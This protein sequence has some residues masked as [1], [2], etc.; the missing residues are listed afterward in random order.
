MDG[1]Y[2]GEPSGVIRAYDAVTGRLA[3]AF[4]PAAYR[5]ARRTA[6]GDIYTPRDA[7]QLGSHQR[8]RVA[9]PG[10][11]AD[12]QCHA[13]LSTAPNAGHSTTRCRS[14]VIALDAATGNLRWRF[15]TVHHDMWDYDVPSQPTLID[16]PTPSGIRRALIQPTKR[17]E[18]FVLDRATGEPIKAVKRDGRASRWHPTRGTAFAD[19]AVLEWK[20]RRFAVRRCASPTCGA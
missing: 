6:D 12:G 2:W 9:R 8:R 19:A 7:E 11:S 3:W 17:G 10:L 18:I 20:C 4:D 13:G 15:Q 14:S 16:L 5:T 1:Q